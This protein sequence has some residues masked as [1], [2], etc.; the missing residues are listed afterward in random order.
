MDFFKSNSKKS[1]SHYRNSPRGNSRFKKILK[2][3]IN[4]SWRHLWPSPAAFERRHG[5]PSS[6]PTCPLHHPLRWWLIRGLE[7][8]V[9]CI[10]W[11][12]YSRPAVAELCCQWVCELVGFWSGAALGATH[13]CHRH[14]SPPVGITY[15]DPHPWLRLISVSALNATSAMSRDV[16]GHSAG[17]IEATAS[18]AL[19]L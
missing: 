2:Q 16:L 19:S 6:P 1:L 14:K 13:W 18:S 3:L 7:S 15:C 12:F 4:F 9:T 11:L 8:K 10:K 17:Q 5:G